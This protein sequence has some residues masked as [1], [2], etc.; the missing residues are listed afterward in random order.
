MPLDGYDVS[1]HLGHISVLSNGLPASAFL[2][3]G[4]NTPSLSMSLYHHT[5][6]AA[7]SSQR[8][9]SFHYYFEDMKPAVPRIFLRRPLQR[10]GPPSHLEHG[11]K[12]PRQPNFRR[13]VHYTM[14]GSHFKIAFGFILLLC[15]FRGLDQSICGATTAY[16]SE[17]ERRSS[18][19]SDETFCGPRSVA[20]TVQIDP[21]EDEQSKFFLAR[22]RSSRSCPVIHK[23]IPEKSYLMFQILI[24]RI[25]TAVV[26]ADFEAAALIQVACRYIGVLSLCSRD[27]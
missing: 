24:R 25:E 11:K 8:L 3:P 4:P 20:L 1:V 6:W 27:M 21:T 16:E 19:R 2:T 22:S 12:T 23:S 7:L 5:C 14:N 13:S 18:P 10:H 17:Y 15:L 26:T 9:G